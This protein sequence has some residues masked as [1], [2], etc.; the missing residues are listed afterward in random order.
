MESK[1]SLQKREKVA[2]IGLAIAGALFWGA[3]VKEPTPVSAAGPHQTA[4][5]CQMLDDAIGS[6]GSMRNRCRE[7]RQATLDRVKGD[8][9]AASAL[10]MV[11]ILKIYANQR[12]LPM[13][14]GDEESRFPKD[15]M[16]NVGRG[17]VMLMHSNP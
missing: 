17:C 9:K 7:I 4:E 8:T 5:A 10:C 6:D 2:I 13:P 16:E 15:V 11:T 12:G 14:K 1:M 3:S